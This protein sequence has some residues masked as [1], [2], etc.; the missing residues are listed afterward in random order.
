MMGSKFKSRLDAIK[1]IERNG[2][3]ITG[4]KHIVKL[5]YAGLKVLS[6]ID[7]L[8]NYHRYLWLS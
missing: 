4:D 6:A 5:R 3:Q 2:G 7:Y 1:C 8:V